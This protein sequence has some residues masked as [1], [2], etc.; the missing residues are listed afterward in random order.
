MASVK[1]INY[2]QHQ[3]GPATLSV[4]ISFHNFLAQWY[5]AIIRQSSP[6]DVTYKSVLELYVVSGEDN[7]KK[8]IYDQLIFIL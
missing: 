8:Y 2:S 1:L 5:L 3:F 4:C 7:P 6:I